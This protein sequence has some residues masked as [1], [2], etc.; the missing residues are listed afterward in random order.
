MSEQTFTVLGMTCEHCVRAVTQ[1]VQA[2]PGVA[3]V[4]VELEDGR[5][6]VRADEHLDDEKI[7]AAVEEA[8]Y[9]MD[10]R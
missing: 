2:V 3:G 5:L 1:E 4:E 9:R 7:R 8:G 10:S 6:T